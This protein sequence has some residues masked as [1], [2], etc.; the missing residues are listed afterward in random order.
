M[1]ARYAIRLADLAKGMSGRQ[2]VVQVEALVREWNYYLG[3]TCGLAQVSASGKA[4]NIELFEAGN[5]TVSLSR[6]PIGHLRAGTPRHHRTDPR[7]AGIPGLERTQALRPA[8]DQRTCLISAR[9]RTLSFFYSFPCEFESAFAI[10]LCNIN[11]P[12]GKRVIMR[13][14]AFFSRVLFPVSAGERQ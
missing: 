12:K 14:G 11:S 5:F 7:T 4:L 1:G 13:W 6:P 10:A 2:V 8:A 3:T 9:F